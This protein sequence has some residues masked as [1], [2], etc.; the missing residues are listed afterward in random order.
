MENSKL[1]EAITKAENK[2]IE[3]SNNKKVL[4]SESTSVADEKKT[5]GQNQTEVKQQPRSVIPKKDYS[6]EYEKAKLAYKI[7]YR[8]T[9]DELY[10]MFVEPLNKKNDLKN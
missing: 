8:P 7:P 3:I 2:W 4:T 6:K 10:S 5:V 1:H 9:M